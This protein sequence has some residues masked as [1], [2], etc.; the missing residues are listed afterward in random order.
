MKYTIK[1]IASAILLATSSYEAMSQNNTSK[2]LGM[3]DFTLLWLL[4]GLIFILFLIALAVAN[5]A[6][7]FIEAKGLWRE[8]FAKNSQKLPIA[9]ILI[10]F[11]Q[12]VFA[13]SAEVKTIEN[14][15]FV[16]SD[17]LFYILIGAIS[18]LS[19]GIISMLLMLKTL[20]QHI[21]GEEPKKESSV[22]KATMNILTDAVPIE[23][24]E[25]VLLDH[26]YDGIKELNNNL[27]PWWVWMFYATIIFSVIYL[28]RFHVTGT[29]PHMAEEYAQ[30]MKEAELQKEAFLAK[31]ANLVDEN[32]VTEITDVA[33]LGEGKTKFVELC[34]ACHGQNG[35]GGVGPN[36]TDEYWLHGGGV[37]NVF[38]T[39]KYGVPAKGMIAWESQLSPSQIQQISSYILS[40]KGTNPANGKAP[41][42]EIWQAATEV[43]T[44][45]TQTVLPADTTKLADEAV[46]LSV[47]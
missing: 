20:V 47:K 29:A 12:S 45:S 10:M 14:E 23:Q 46:K 22:Y 11:S 32:S 44:D 6:K 8:H 30:Q 24:E 33:L 9:I 43:K 4:V 37:S 39:I 31:A 41:Q 2:A 16:M 25:S 35:E 7:Q 34:A 26:N 13:Q 21:R 40:L 5:I 19:I 17:T 1:Y 36:L 3:N 18:L 15:V 42:G 27:P 38:K 28:V